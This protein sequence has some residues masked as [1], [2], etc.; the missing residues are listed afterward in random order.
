MEQSQHFGG[1]TGSNTLFS[2][3]GCNLFNQSGISY[4]DS[5]G[6][7]HVMIIGGA[8]VGSPATK[9]DKVLFY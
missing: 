6:V 2:K 7:P 4:I 3:T 8:K 1:A 9:Q 5:Q